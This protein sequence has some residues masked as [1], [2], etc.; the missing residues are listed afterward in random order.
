MF[1]PSEISTLYVS[2]KYGDDS[3]NFGFSRENKYLAEG[4]VATLDNALSY[5]AELRNGGHN[6]PITIYILDEEYSIS[7]PIVLKPEM[8]S[9]T[10][11]PYKKTLISGGIKITD[12][13]KDTFNGQECFSAYIPQV[14]DDGLWFTDFYVDGKRAKVTRFPDSGTLDPEAV[15]NEDTN[16]HASCEWFIAKK[17]D[18]KKIATFKNF[19]DCFISYNH[20]WIDEHTPIKSYDLETGRID[21]A[22]ASRF[23]LSSKHGRSAFHYIIENVAESFKNPNEW[24]LD[25]ETSTVYYIPE[26]SDQT[27]ENITAYAPVTDKLFVLNGTVDNKLK[28]VRLEGFQFAYTKGDYKSLGSMSIDTTSAPKAADPQSVHLAHGSIELYNTHRCYIENCQLFCLGVHAITVNE[29]CTQTQLCNNHIYDIGAGGIKIGGIGY[30]EFKADTNIDERLANH[31]NTVKNNRIDLCGRRYYAGCGIL[32]KH[33][34]DNYVAHNEISNLF[35][36]GISL[37]WVWG[38]SDSISHD[39]LVEKNLI[40]NIGSGV[41]SD[42]GGIY[43]LG[44][45]SGTI[46]RNNIIHDVNCFDYGAWGIYT[47][48]GSSYIIVENNLCY[49]IGKNGFH[50][51]YG[52]MNTVRNNIFVKS[53][54]GA[55]NVSGTRINNFAIFERNILVTEGNQPTYLSMYGDES[56]PNNI[57]AHNN[58]LYNID[59]KVKAMGQNVNI[60]LEE[61]QKD[62]GNDKYS[63]EADPLFVDYANNDFR[64]KENSPAYD[65]GFEDIDFS[66]VGIIK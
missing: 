52:R 27:P 66:D 26:N 47:D 4:P 3:H 63:I 5:V 50:Q 36:T 42:M 35:Y 54:Q 40:Y 10:I 8:H 22:Y 28:N 31:G 53:G 19:G 17:E 18:L 65:I 32:I 1:N 9:I 43:T 16:L 20:Y 23:S 46:I 21:F 25:R 57:I 30:G 64:L 41:L 39:N 55:A 44:K 2:R 49:N 7:S 13:K 61:F 33:S 24:Y 15:G 6:Q 14:A 58:L 60:S 34:Y 12:F 51:H 48:E 59:G 37:G 29:G 11:K 56:A 38:Y 45:Q 62:Y